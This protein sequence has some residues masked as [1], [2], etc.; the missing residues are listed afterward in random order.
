MLKN[1]LVLFNADNVAVG[2][3]AL[4]LAALHRAHLVVASP[5]VDL[6]LAPYMIAEMPSAT[7][8][9]LQ[10]DTERTVRRRLDDFVS[11][12][13][14]MGV[15]ATAHAIPV[16]L[17][18][19]PEHLCSR[20][21]RHFDLTLIEQANPD[22]KG[23]QGEIIEAI[24]FESGRPMLV[25]PYVHRTPA[26]FDRVLVAW[27]GSA[28]AARAV[29]DALPLITGAAEV[30]IVT[31]VDGG[32]E[33]EDESGLDVAQHLARHGVAARR[34]RLT[35]AGDVASTLLSHMADSGT[36][37]LVMG[38]YGHSRLREMMLGGA[39]RDILASMTAPVLMAH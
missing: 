19:G 6:A 38:G 15:E 35:S 11:Q 31:V 33:P 39:T 22:V 23:L 1:L 2:P 5:V 37:L 4:S 25:V 14:A 9:S 10:Q 24:L 12:A 16:S 26:A 13:K 27:D 20:L 18:M 8:E 17:G 32:K 7:W 28:P 30:E 36:D 29:N 34:N 3:Y 21:A